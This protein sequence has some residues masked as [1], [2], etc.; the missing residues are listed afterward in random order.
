[1]SGG[2]GISFTYI[3]IYTSLFLSLSRILHEGEIL[4][5]YEKSVSSQPSLVDVF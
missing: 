4:K 3:Y 2:L 1:M 5:R